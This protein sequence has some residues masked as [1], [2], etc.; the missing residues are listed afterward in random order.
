MEEDNKKKVLVRE[1]GDQ[2]ILS[3]IEPILKSG[4]RAHLRVEMGFE[5]GDF[6]FDAGRMVYAGCSAIKGQEAAYHLISWRNGTFSLRKIKEISEQNVD[7]EWF[8]FIKFYEQEIDKIVLSFVPIIGGG[9]YFELRDKQGQKVLNGDYFQKPMPKGELIELLADPRIEKA[10]PVTR[11]AERK[12]LRI[13]KGSYVL[14]LRYLADVKYFVV[15]VFS[16]EA[17][18]EIYEQWLDNVFE[19]KSIE[20]VSKALELADKKRVRG[21]VLVI[22]DS[23]TTRAILEDTLSEYRFNVLSAEDGY[24]GL[25]IAQAENPDMIFLDVMMPKLDGYEVLKRL[26]KDD[27]FK[28]LP[29]V[30]LTSKGLAHDDGAAFREGANLYIEKPF[31]TK[32]ILA[33]VENV[34]GLED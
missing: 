8:D 20:A 18:Q 14:I 19:P 17:Y 2:N 7:I 24:Q 23:P 25:V 32:K 31:T 10:Y 4:I 33:I 12:V 5:N 16:E 34:L 1:L 3:V 21:T 15:A 22:D 26:R 30:M 11:G 13:T 28:T 9:M 29:I 27:R 6:Y